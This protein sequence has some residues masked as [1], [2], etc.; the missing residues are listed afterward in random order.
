VKAETL[1]TRVGTGVLVTVLTMAAINHVPALR[2]IVQ[3][4]R[5][6]G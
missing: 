5:T 2:A 1:I 6:N 4:D 3:G